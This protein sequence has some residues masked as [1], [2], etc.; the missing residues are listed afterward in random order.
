[1][2]RT[3]M[4]RQ[5][6]AVATRRS[7]KRGV[8]GVAMND[9]IGQVGIRFAALLLGFGVALPG[10]AASVRQAS[11]QGE[12]A[13]VRQVRVTFAQSVMPLGDVRHD[14]PFTLQCQGTVPPG[15]G[16]WA[17]DK[18]WVYDF[19]DDVGPG[20]RCTVEP[21][22]GWMPKL[23]EAGA[24]QAT[25]FRFQTGGP[26]VKN[27]SPGGGDIEED[28]HFLLQLT[29]P[30]DEAS[31]L[32]HTRCEVE[33]VGE[34]LPV[35]IERGAVLAEVLKAEGTSRAE[36]A[37]SVLLRC[38][39]PLPA[40]ARMKLVWDKGIAARGSPSVVTTRAQVF[41]Y[42]VRSAF[43]AEFSC[44][45]ERAQSP[46]LPLRPMMVKLSAPVSR[47]LASQIVLKPASGAA[48][49]PS[50]DK[51]DQAETV[52]EVKFNPPLPES[53]AFTVVL[54]SGFRDESGRNLANADAFP[55]K[56][57]TSSMPPLAK[58]AAA[59]FGVIEL[60]GEPNQPPLVP[61]TV[62]HVEK[63]LM[64]KGLD[65]SL[66]VRTKTVQGDADI[67]RWMAKVRR[68]HESSFSAKELG[69][70]KSEWMEWV[71]EDDGE[72]GTRRYQREKQIGTRELSLLGGV[73]E[74]RKLT[75]PAAHAN[76]PR[77]FEVVGIPLSD[78]GYHVIELSSA[79]LGASLLAR[80]APMYVRT[81]VLVSNMGV[82]VK[83]G[84]DGAS[85]W[86][87][88]LDK[89]KP[90]ADA[91][92]A[93]NDCRGTALWRGRTNKDGLARAQQA[94]SVARDERCLVQDGLF[95]TARKPMTEGPF[96]G[97]TDL[98]FVFT[99][100]QKGIESWRFQHPTASPE[101]DSGDSSVRA[102]TVFDRSL[103]RAGE[104]VS[105][106]HFVRSEI[107]RGLGALPRDQMP[108]TL[109][110][111]HVGSG[112]E[113]SQALTWASGQQAL[114]SWA[115]PKEAKLGVYEVS[116]EG[117]A[118]SGRRSLSS[119]RFRV[120]EF[121]LP[122][123]DA[124]LSGPKEVQLAPREMVLSARM[125]YLSGGA[126]AQAVAKV[127][128]VLRD[129][130]PRFTG[131]EDYSFDAPHEA[132]DDGDRST[133]SGDSDAD[134]G[135]D[136]AGPGT[137]RVVADKLPFS[138][139]RE[140]AGKVVIKDLPQRTRAGTLHAEMTFTDPN[141]EVQTVATSVPVW[142][143]SVVLGIRSA[144]WVGT[145]GD[146]QGRTRFHVLALDTQGR[147][148]KGQSVSVQA[149][150]SQ[151][152]S[153]RKRIVGGFYAYDNRTEVKAL[154]EVCSG[155]T[156][157][158]GLLLCETKLE[159]AGEVELVA[160]AQDDAKRRSQAATTVWITRQGELW[161][162]QD[163]DDR[164]DVLP[165]KTR[166]E[167]GETARLQVRMPF[168]EATVLVSIEREGIIEQR[169]MTLSGKDPV[170]ELPIPRAKVGPDGELQSWAPNVYVSVMALRGRIREVPWYS[171]FTWGWR[172]PVEWARAFWYE[173]REYQAPTAMVD[174]SRPAFKLGVA[175]LRI[176]TADH[177]LKVE[178]IPEK[179][180]Y[181]IRQTAKVQV[182]VTHQG[183]PVTG[184]FA[185]AAVDESLLALSGNESWQLLDAMMQERAWG[186]E[187]STAQ[188]EIVGRRHYGRK[189]VAA[190][191]GGGTGA[192]R[193]LF[194]TLLLW[195][196]SVTLDA[197]GEGWV[198]VPINDALTSF[199]LVAVAGSGLSRFG[200]GSASIRV[201][202]DLQILSGLPPLV[203][204]GDRFEAI[205]TVRN[206]TSQSLRVQASLTAQAERL[207][208]SGS[209][210]VPVTLKLPPQQI[211]LPPDSA[212]ELR[213]PVDV[214]VDVG[215]LN[216]E[217]SVVADGKPG[218]SDRIKL[219]QQV[220][221]AVP[222]RVMQATL[223]QLT[224]PYTLPVAPPADALSDIRG[225]SRLARGGIRVGLQPTLTSNLPGI[226]RYFEQYPYVCLEQKVAKA[227]GL[228]DAKMWA[229]ISRQLPSYLDGDG[230]A[231]YFPPMSG[232]AGH[233]TDYLTAHLLAVSHESGFELPPQARDAMLQG[234]SA[235]VQGRLQREVWSPA[236]PQRGLMNDVRRLAAIEA[237]S[238]YG[239]AEARML[240]TVA[241][242]PQQ[243]PTA[244]V[245]NWFNILQRLSTVPSREQRL[246]EAEQ[247]LRSRLTFA[248]TTLRFSTEADDF[249]WWM[250][251]NPDA[252]AARLILSVM[253]L[254]SWQEDLPRMMVGSLGRQ[255]QGAWL[256]TH[257]NLW[258]SVALDKFAQ[259]FEKV[260]VSGMTRARL[261]TG[262]ASQ[263][264]SKS[265]KGQVLSLPWAAQLAQGT[266]PVA[267]PL[268][269]QHEGAGHPWLTVQALAAVPLKAPLN[270]GYAI[271]KSVTVEDAGNATASSGKG[272]GRGAVLRVRLEIDAQSDMTWVALNDPVPG[273]ATILGSGLGRDSALATQGERNEGMWPVYVERAFDGYRA[274]FDYL[275][276]GK[277]V[278]TYTVRL[279]N[280]GRFLLPPTRIEAMYAPETFGESPNAPVEVAP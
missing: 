38:Q 209:A 70:P 112:T 210:D 279:N 17:T 219:S 244:A 52:D 250:M 39:R 98:A 175:A 100:W 259:R 137:D 116:L 1:M 267:A 232:E 154:G 237:L 97:K 276:K 86:V 63:S 7:T 184:D 115:I 239:R 245:I 214:P 90:V 155:A 95:V 200:T 118:P 78:S 266:G 277:H 106:K 142:P 207:E 251:D 145:G 212:R 8:T 12:V 180:Q 77:P 254:P 36:A 256:N 230:L 258:A 198:K 24:L 243:W 32:A 231:S 204:E 236:G 84:R 189:A 139:D 190:G 238:R 130:T 162:S 16:R 235:F 120:E 40:G 128:A 278:V 226:R 188:N 157:A 218:M 143:S 146:A 192:T 94:F 89:G 67:L 229:D 2:I 181:T 165:E 177:E 81:G 252:N 147:P 80:A 247:I 156:D 217:A 18:V 241:L 179:A 50:F 228:R 55:L 225:A 22:A 109:K 14:D 249:W 261:G 255:R 6:L 183:K 105:M 203:R 222:V 111:T 3:K 186:V 132:S 68:Y 122:L 272:Y 141:G 33:G 93:I 133:H 274:Y 170:I 60:M 5:L 199:R 82:H 71:T 172:S 135:N 246:N 275:P 48:L 269:V 4:G 34:R 201:T 193:E 124:R 173:G 11:P 65:T 185:F 153:T 171:F 187:T 79:R 205:L 280:P 74:A 72:G 140:G 76:D 159:Q 108:D 21:R 87:T 45:R 151:T 107:L 54:P 168:R 73:K 152:F 248:G 160:Q 114:S 129:R 10:L 20:V 99:D 9:R 85:V 233:G 119:G 234:L 127:T 206:T 59:P 223:T 164:M 43:V 166:Y 37:R 262:E 101:D 117:N 144:R 268:L 136:G 56:V 208:H 29:G 66:G 271:R 167:P 47:K 191:G 44:E 202:Q 196:G 53:V 211:D 224:A 138:T 64:V 197:K 102:H 35:V 227:V 13:Q 125:S 257:A 178:V 163:N 221:P 148:L 169:V 240:D 265:P 263:D 134:E 23:K 92:V 273:G 28:A 62:R 26:A 96:K 270:A 30:V 242:A 103:L 88:S 149:R 91:E 31:M 61:V 57:A 46:C 215:S 75:V 213:W 69:R 216:W 121:R 15:G 27:V 174:L 150:L 41:D 182:R 83:L 195:Q 51:D 264:W 131:Y 194:D 58:F 158:R 42:Q 110:I 176:G 220:L 104:T 161:F 253:T 19:S 113:Y 260:P 123:V 126:V 49:K 25:S